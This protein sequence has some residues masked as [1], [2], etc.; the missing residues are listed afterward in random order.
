MSSTPAPTIPGGRPE[1]SPAT[2]DVVQPAIAELIEGFMHDLSHYRDAQFYPPE[3]PRRLGPI[4]SIHQTLVNHERKF[5][6]TIH[7]RVHEGTIFSSNKSVDRKSRY[8]KELATLLRERMTLLVLIRPGVSPEEAQRF[9]D[10]LISK[11]VSIDGPRQWSLGP[12]V[13]LFR[14]QTGFSDGTEIL[15]AEEIIAPPDEAKAEEDRSPLQRL[16]ESME[17]HSRLEQLLGADRDENAN[18]NFLKRLFEVLGHDARLDWT[19]FDSIREVVESSLDFLQRAKDSP[20]TAERLTLLSSVGVEGCDLGEAVRWQLLRRFVPGELLPELPR[21]ETDL[22]SYA[23]VQEGALPKSN[24]LESTRVEWNAPQID[25]LKDWFQSYYANQRFVVEYL[26]MIVELVLQDPSREKELREGFFRQI[27][28][29]LQEDHTARKLVDF[30]KEEAKP[31]EAVSPMGWASILPPDVVESTSSVIPIDKSTTHRLLG[32]TDRMPKSCRTPWQVQILRL[33]AP[34]SDA[35]ATLSGGENMILDVLINMPPDSCSEPRGSDEDQIVGPSEVL[36]Q[37][38]ALTDDYAMDVVFSVL[39]G[40]RREQAVNAGWTTVLKEITSNHSSLPSWIIGRIDA[41]IRK[42]ADLVM[43]TLPLQPLTM[44][45]RDHFQGVP[46]EEQ[47]ELVSRLSEI[48]TPHV[49]RLLTI[50]LTSDSE[51][52]RR[53]AREAIGTRFNHAA[54]IILHTLLDK[55]NHE[56]PRLDEVAHLCQMMAYYQGA[57]GRTALETIAHER[58][59]LLHKWSRALR[60]EAGAALAA[61]QAEQD[62]KR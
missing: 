10:F 48:D 50:G 47:R 2:E 49:T 45:L 36:R 34:P 38:L 4:N 17:I 61:W 60:K 41:L 55:Q 39:F 24:G 28:Y 54:F 7:L 53:L 26:S 27:I 33:L 16:L 31:D 52:I 14:F 42:D 25:R 13:Q 3:H 43:A 30:F 1:N 23:R 9:A 51:G 21:D 37:C 12:N 46:E 29:S 57:A 18:L 62:L 44:A 19:S 56:E 8:A 40:P 6:T 20:G 5:R 35:L 11:K 59:G 22:D 58:K 32:L 15:T